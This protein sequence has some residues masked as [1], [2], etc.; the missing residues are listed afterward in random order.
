MLVLATFDHSM[1]L[2]QALLIL[3]REGIERRGIM[4]VPLDALGRNSHIRFELPADWKE[5]AFEIGMATGTASA[6]FGICL[7]FVWD[8]GPLIW[9][10]LTAIGGFGIGYIIYGL[11]YH[12][13]WKAG[14]PVKRPE[15]AV[16]VRGKEE[17]VDLIRQVLW[18]HKA[19]SLG[20]VPEQKQ[21]SITP[22]EPNEAP[23]LT[24]A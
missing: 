17:N 14:D 15:A 24:N 12:L 20:I 5:R 22:L 7:G 1:E 6:V 3:E 23:R 10:L 8:W 4:V 18:Q 2:E 21:G 16:I 11:V 13:L 9:G 19:L